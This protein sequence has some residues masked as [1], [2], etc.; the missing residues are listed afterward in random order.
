MSKPAVVFIAGVTI[1]G[2]P[3]PQHITVPFS[4]EATLGHVAQA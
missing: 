1:S 4:D 2:T 3:C